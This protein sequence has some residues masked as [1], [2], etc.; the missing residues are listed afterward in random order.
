V[1][2]TSRAQGPAA[3]LDDIVDVLRSSPAFDLT[4]E[5]G[6][7]HDLLD[8][9]LQTAQVLRLSHPDDPELQVAG[10]VHDL[11]HLLPP[12]RDDVHADVAAIFVRPVLGDRIAE[13]VRLHVP[14]KRYL[15]TTDPRYREGLDEGS[16]T[17]LGHQGGEMSPEE[18]S[19]FESE[20]L[21]ADAV[22]L[23]RADEA[24]K[25]PGLAV[26]DLDTWLAPLRSQVRRR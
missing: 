7:P 26:P 23:R 16:I 3:S 19:A 14:A 2:E 21:Y 10:L 18:V 1:S 12:R 22:A 4:T 8:H 9:S 5:P 15:V 11:G 20:P 25:V 6:P 13:L 17:S 24:G